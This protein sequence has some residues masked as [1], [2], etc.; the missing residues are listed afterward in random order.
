VAHFVRI[1]VGLA[2]CSAAG[3]GFLPRARHLRDE[4]GPLR[5]GRAAA[6]GLAFLVPTIFLLGVWRLPVR[7]PEIVCVALLF[8]AAGAQWSRGVGSLEPGRAAAGPGYLSLSFAIVAAA[9]GVFVWKVTVVPVWTWDHYMVWGMKSRI[10]VTDGMLDLKFLQGYPFFEANA[11]Y[12]LGLPAAWRIL[13]LGAEPAAI[14]FKICHVF[15]GVGVVLAVNQI[16]AEAG[17]GVLWRDAASGFVAVSPLFWDTES[18]GNAEMP[19]CWFALTGLGLLLGSP[20]LPGRFGWVAGCVIGLLP[21]IKKEG[22]TLAVL[23]FSARC[24]V[25]WRRAGSSVRVEGVL[26]IGIA[27]GALA[28]AALLV[29]RLL[30]PRGLPFFVGSW[31]TRAWGRL[32][33]PGP[34]LKAVGR[35]MLSADWFGFWIVFAGLLALALVRRETPALAVFAA[36]LGQISLYVFTYFATYLDP[37]AHVNASFFRILGALLPLG[38]V[39]AGFLLPRENRLAR[40][41]PGGTR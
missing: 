6:V 22:L 38:V 34:L 39:G 8:A 19:L 4:F 25:S 18:L 20:P 31:W 13:T 5:I 16:L 1:A 15:F 3:A 40:A 23:L 37:V 17:V 21:W 24:A 41:L 11:D 36:V 14:D 10:M 28:A 9:L 2:L 29:E 12:P 35:E 7:A 32:L 27:A 30:L 26:S 33:G